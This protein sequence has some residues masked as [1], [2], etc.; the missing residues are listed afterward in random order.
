MDVGRL[1]VK[2]YVSLVLLSG[3]FVDY[4]LRISF[5]RE[6]KLGEQNLIA[7]P[8]FGERGET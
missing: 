1:T 6:V 3:G 2:I 8:G 7:W 4:G 5:P